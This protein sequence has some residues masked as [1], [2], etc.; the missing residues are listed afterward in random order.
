MH[1]DVRIA[2]RTME[3]DITAD[4]FAAMIG[5]TLNHDYHAA[6]L[7]AFVRIFPSWENC[8]I[9][10]VDHMHHVIS[11]MEEKDVALLQL[12][13]SAVTSEIAIN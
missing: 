4:D 12:I 7:T 3:V 13:A 8:D 6:M 2:R 11:K 9:D 5:D 1:T 10:W